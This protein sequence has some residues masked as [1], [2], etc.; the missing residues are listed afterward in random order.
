M[1]RKWLDRN[2]RKKAYSFNIYD[3]TEKKPL[4]EDIKEYLSH[5]TLIQYKNLEYLKKYKNDSTDE[6]R[7]YLRNYTFPNTRHS[8]TKGGKQIIKNVRQGDFGEILTT[9]L[10]EEF[11]D[12]KVP[13]SKLRYKFNKDR[14]VFCT[15]LISH[16]NGDVITDLKYYEV[17]TRTSK[18]VYKTAT[19]AYEGLERD[20]SKPTEAIANFLSNHYYEKAEVLFEVGKEEEAEPFYNLAKQFSDIVKNP[21]NYNRSFEIVLIIERSYFKEKLLK[22]L[23]ELSLKLL[24]LEVTLVL[25]DNLNDLVINTFNNAEDIAVKH[26]FPIAIT[27]II[28][29]IT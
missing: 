17:K 7:E 6:L 1:I 23:N 11:T 20:E 14:S 10:V 9:L 15:D 27:P 4:D 16:N 28:S 5:Q 19:E 26:V 18:S 24:P 13:I 21:Q 2:L 22:K 25:V 29:S 3:I 8:F 12:L